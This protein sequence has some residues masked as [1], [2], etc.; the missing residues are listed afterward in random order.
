MAACNQF[1]RY[2]KGVLQHLRNNDTDES[3]NYDGCRSL[4]SVPHPLLHWIDGEIKVGN[5]LGQRPIF[6]PPFGSS[7]SILGGLIQALYKES[8]LIIRFQLRSTVER[9]LNCCVQSSG[10]QGQLG[11][12][13]GLKIP[14]YLI[15]TLRKWGHPASQRKESLQQ[16]GKT[17]V[18]A[19][20]EGAGSSRLV[21]VYNPKHNPLLLLGTRRR[22]QLANYLLQLPQLLLNFTSPGT[23]KQNEVAT[24]TAIED[25]VMATATKYTLPPLPYAYDALEPHISAQIM[26]IHHT[27]HHQAYVTNLN[28]ALASLVTFSQTSD[29]PAQIALQQA[30]KFNGGGH[31]NHSLFWENLTPAGS[32]G[33]S[34]EAGPHVRKAITERWGGE[35]KFK[36][37]FTKVLLGLQGSGWGWLV[38]DEEFGSL[39][40]I[41]TKDQD[42]VPA[43]KVPIFGV[44]MWEHAY[45]LQYLNNKAEY[46][47]G[48][49]H[50]INWDTAEKR[51]SGG[52]KDAFSVLKASM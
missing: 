2:R 5:I 18:T 20:A 34:H 22:M 44:D 48:I 30:V 29:I 14:K 17:H 7:S 15:T 8:K 4:P 32:P 41:T 21:D 12:I 24:S 39:E 26:T 10:R 28:A 40:I 47:K 52:R 36:D 19:A 13:A 45:Y 33:A 49:W 46:I 23:A 43:G 38:R 1:Q 31:I 11:E 6:L 35:E 37:A 27:K 16:R 3:R 9:G 42:P 25:I 50:I 51:Y